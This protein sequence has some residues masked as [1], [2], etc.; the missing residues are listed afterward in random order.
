MPIY[1]VMCFQKGTGDNL[2]FWKKD[3]LIDE[4]TLM[5]YWSSRFRFLFAYDLL[6][7]LDI[8]KPAGFLIQSTEKNVLG[9]GLFLISWLKKENLNKQ[10]WTKIHKICISIQIRSS[11]GK[12]IRGD[13][14]SKINNLCRKTRGKHFFKFRIVQKPLPA[15]DR[16][17]GAVETGGLE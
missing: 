1:F 2:S 3:G 15:V 10:S 11:P 14:M 4:Q 5:R 6:S 16:S 9:F 7:F 13:R 12:G 8:K 17:P